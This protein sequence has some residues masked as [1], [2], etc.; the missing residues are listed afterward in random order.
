MGRDGFNPNMLWGKTKR[1][2]YLILK[3][4][5]VLVNKQMVAVVFSFV[6]DPIEYMWSVTI[7]KAGL[8]VGPKYYYYYFH[9]LVQTTNVGTEMMTCQ[10]D[11][12]C[13]ITAARETLALHGIMVLN[14]HTFNARYSIP[15]CVLSLAKTV[16]S[17]K[18]QLSRSDSSLI[19]LFRLRWVIQA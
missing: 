11:S 9:Q 5:K 19:A 13:H 8:T 6:S 16:L 15:N 14:S 4:H 7:L 17:G 10:H 1:K 12:L 18:T 3:Q 2:Q